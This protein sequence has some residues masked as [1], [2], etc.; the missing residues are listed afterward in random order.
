M[1]HIKMIVTDLDGT[2]LRTDK[3]VS[4]H[5]I[6]TLKRC[7]E[8]GIK[9]VYA[10]A[11]GGSAERIAPSGLFDG[12]ITMNGAV[13]KIAVNGAVGKISMNEA[14]DKIEVAGKARAA[15]ENC[16]IIIYS[17]LIPYK[18]ARPLLVACAKQGIR[19]TS[20]IGGMHYSNFPVSDFWP[21]LTNFQIVD[22]ERHAMDAEKIYSPAPTHQERQVIEQLLPSGLYSVSTADITGALLQ[23]M[24]EEATKAKAVAALAKHWGIAASEIVAFGDELNDID[25]LMYAGIGVA[26]GN[27]LESVK[28]VSNYICTSNDEDGI[29]G[30]I[31]ANV[32]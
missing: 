27:A 28:A 31:E 12:K 29:A 18:T 1:P 7:R 24:H 15:E 20:E 26:M 30:W 32:V 17:R 14:A 21:R 10:T 13:G 8:S 11:R 6:E 5:T 25:M 19:I 23:I 16:D 4:Q 9:I 3:T 22:F 2:L